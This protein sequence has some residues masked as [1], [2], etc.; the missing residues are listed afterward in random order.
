MVNQLN[1]REMQDSRQFLQGELSAIDTILQEMIEEF[2]LSSA[3]STAEDIPEEAW[4]H[5]LARN[6]A[7][8]FLDDP[9]EDLYTVEDGK[10]I[11]Y[12]D[13]T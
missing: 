6:P 7:F 5:A 4:L 12:E 1:L 3:L 13:E 2:A 9:S 11:P 8:E 10:P